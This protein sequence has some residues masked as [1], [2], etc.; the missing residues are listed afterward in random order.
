VNALLDL[1]PAVS[2]E[3][4]M[5]AQQLRG[6]EGNRPLHGSVHSDNTEDHHISPWEPFDE[7]ARKE[8]RN[9]L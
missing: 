5:S 3:D 6:I 7:H 4:G 9:E 1:T 2:A 8:Y